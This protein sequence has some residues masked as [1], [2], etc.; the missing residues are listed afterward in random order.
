M[1][2]VC[3]GHMCA[4]NMKHGLFLGGGEGDGALRHLI[5]SLGNY[6]CAVSGIKLCLHVE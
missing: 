1:Q 6:E 4:Q 5:G 2:R 3:H